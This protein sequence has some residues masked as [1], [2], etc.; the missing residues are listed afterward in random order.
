M[1][2]SFAIAEMHPAKVGTLVP[3]YL[4]GRLYGFLAVTLRLSKVKTVIPKNLET[5]R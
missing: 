5:I 2:F 4:S 1:P 3:T